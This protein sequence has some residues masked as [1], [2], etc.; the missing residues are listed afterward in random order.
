[1]NARELALKSGRIVCPICR[2]KGDCAVCDGAGCAGCDGSA[3][4]D[5]C[6]GS[7]ILRDPFGIVGE[8]LKD[9]GA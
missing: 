1:M 2:G 7:G 3:Q 4:C 6:S 5:E 9:R 8:M